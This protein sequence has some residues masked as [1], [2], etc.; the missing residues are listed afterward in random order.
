MSDIFISYA[1]MDK[2]RVESLAKALEDYGWSVWWDPRIPA[3][4][5]FDEIIEQAINE[6]RCIIVVWSSNSVSSRWVR[7]EASEGVDRQILVPVMIEAVR[8]PLAFKQIQ[9]APLIDWDGSLPHFGFDKL[10]EDIS[11]LLGPAS[12]ITTARESPIGRYTPAVKVQPLDGPRLLSANALYREFQDNPID[13]SNKYAGKTVVLEGLRGDI[14]LRS[15]GV[16]AAVHIADSGR[17]NALIL[18]FSD[19]NDLASIDRGQKFR[20]RGTVKSYEYSIV[21]MEDCTI[22][23]G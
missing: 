16:G 11:L 5:Q 13:A 17:P 1:S 10:V 2:L 6:A 19:R 15:D 7:A 9:A 20:F 8:I 3:G 14:V 18:R 4:K 21:W 22:E 12:A 23:G